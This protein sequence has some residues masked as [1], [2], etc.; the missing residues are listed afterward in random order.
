M[1]CHLPGKS[2]QLI[3]S[4]LGVADHR[5]NFLGSFGGIVIYVFGF[6]PCIARALLAKIER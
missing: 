4:I 1:R 3:G 6:S 2:D 5:G